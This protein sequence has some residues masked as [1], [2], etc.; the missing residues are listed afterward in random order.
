MHGQKPD[1]CLVELKRK[2]VMNDAED[3]VLASD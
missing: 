3:E 2:G 1:P